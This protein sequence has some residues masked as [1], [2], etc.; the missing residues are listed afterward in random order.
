MNR[1]H[2]VVKRLANILKYLK[3]S[4]FLNKIRTGLCQ[5][6]IF[7]DGTWRDGVFK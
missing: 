7:K 1:I 4:L 6:A 3:Q 2:N 5:K